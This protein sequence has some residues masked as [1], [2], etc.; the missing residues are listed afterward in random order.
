MNSSSHGKSK[1]A[2]FQSYPNNVLYK[3]I[4]GH[5]IC[6]SKNTIFY[7]VALFLF[8][9]IMAFFFFLRKQ[10]DFLFCQ[11]NTHIYFLFWRHSNQIFFPLWL[12]E[13]LYWFS[14][15]AKS[16]RTDLD[17]MTCLLWWEAETIIVR[18]VEIS[19][20]DGWCQYLDECFQIPIKQLSIILWAGSGLPV[21]L[22]LRGNIW[23]PKGREY[24]YWAW[25]KSN[26]KWNTHRSH[27]NHKTELLCA[28]STP[29]HG[30][31]GPFPFPIY[32]LLLM[33]SKTIHTIHSDDPFFVHCIW[34]LFASLFKT[35]IVSYL[36][37]CYKL[38]WLMSHTEDTMSHKNQASR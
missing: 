20:P 22:G 13:I 29:T 33:C 14:G 28:L 6:T 7:Q 10:E 34:H 18:S 27:Q 11:H 9:Q 24:N 37:K 38:G 30:G 15:K 12:Q 32:L 25:Q 23:R 19:H 31:K 2:V 8:A 21:F 36:A 26:N 35:G 16:P 4:L 17:I 1:L 3:Y 5:L